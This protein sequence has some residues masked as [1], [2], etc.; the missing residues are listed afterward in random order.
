MIGRKTESKLLRDLAKNKDAEFVVVYGRR[1]VGKTYL[2]RETFGNKFDFSYTGIANV[3]T[4]VQIKEF[5]EALRAHGSAMQEPLQ[6]W[7][8]AFRA[9]KKLVEQMPKNESKVIFIDEMP[10]MDSRKSNF[11]SAFEHF[12]NGYASGVKNLLLIV[13]GSATSWIT[14][15]IFRNKGGLYN[16]VTRQIYLQ[17][18]TLSE[19]REYYDSK[20]IVMNIH[21]MIESYM[22]FGGIPYYLNM[23]DRKYSLALNVDALCFAKD[24]PLRLEFD[25]LLDTL[26]AD[27]EKY[28]QVLESMQ[29]KKIGLTREELKTSIDFADGGNLTKIL[30]DLEGSGFIRKYKPYGGIKKGALYQLTDPFTLFHMN[31]IKRIDNPRYWS[32]FTDN[33]AHRSWSGYAFEQVCLAHIEQIKSALGITGVLTDVSSWRSRSD[34]ETGAQIDLVIERND[35]VVNLCEMK[36]ASEPYTIDKK[37]DL[38]LRNKI[39]L[40]KNETKTRSAVHLTFVTPYGLVHNAYASVAQ[41][42]ITM[43]ELL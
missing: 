39:G 22:I 5:E 20:E 8:D 11:V 6:T 42:E 2:V 38:A 10:W 4:S 13:C 3:S 27:S 30:V 15:K 9:L 41:S 35:N 21:D 19:C 1:R 33:A 40:F 18:F 32:S 24:A 34:A 28:V 43:D 37:Q 7:F 29:R 12:W 26:F 14:K 17:P 36:Y 25:R 16:R 31:F 23:F